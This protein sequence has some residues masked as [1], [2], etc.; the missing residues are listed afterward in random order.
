MSK[1]NQPVQETQEQPAHLDLLDWLRARR[2]QLLGAGLL[3]GA[4]IALTGADLSIPRFWYIAGI[5]A[6]FVT[7]FGWMTGSKVTN[8]LHNPQYE[9]LID[10]DA[11]VLD[12]GIYRLPPED[13]RE[14]TVLDDDEF[15]NSTYDLTQLGPHLYVGKQVDLEDL[16]VVG[17][18]RG[19]L[20]DRDLTR[21]LRAVHECR[22]QLQAD[23]QRGFILETSAFVV[24][25]RATRNTVSKVIDVFEEGSLPDSGDSIE[26]AIDDELADFGLD[27]GGDNL[28]DL[29]DDEEIDDLDHKSGFEFNTPEDPSD[30]NGSMDAQEVTL[31][32]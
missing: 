11:R 9:W 2:F 17:T 4:L 22:G 18:W 14:L 8:W 26:Q 13:F 28:E 32:D 19:T 25:R 1:T 20:D 15:E 23:A 30:R 10:L 6:I 29:V 31:N 16:T 27:D 7:P 5:S 24:V 21:A 3:G 12:G